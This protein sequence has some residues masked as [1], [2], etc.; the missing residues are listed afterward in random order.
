[1]HGCVHADIPLMHADKNFTSTSTHEGYSSDFVHLQ[2]RGFRGSSIIQYVSIFWFGHVSLA[3]GVIKL[4][5][6]Y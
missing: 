1:M 5:M 3:F 2:R 6:M 4:F